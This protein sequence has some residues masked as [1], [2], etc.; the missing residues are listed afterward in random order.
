MKISYYNPIQNEATST[1]HSGSLSAKVSGSL[2][3]RPGDLLL[4]VTDSG[5]KPT[6]K[7]WENRRKMESNIL[8]ITNIHTMIKRLFYFIRIANDHLIFSSMW[9][10]HF[11]HYTAILCKKK[12]FNRKM[13]FHIQAVQR[14]NISVPVLP[15]WC[16]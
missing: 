1:S 3:P 7:G 12:S 14:F 15:T 4:S 9:R 5:R 6:L 13:T 11:Q 2:N 10:D 16:S 8:H